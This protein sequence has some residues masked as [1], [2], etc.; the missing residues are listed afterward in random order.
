M[1]MSTRTLISLLLVLLSAVLSAQNELEDVRVETYYI[2][3]ANDATDEDGGTLLAGSRSYRIYVDLGPGCSLLA[4]FGDTNHVFSVSTNALFFNNADRGKTLGHEIAD[5]RLDE[6]TVALDSWL[7]L[8]GASTLRY[9]VEKSADTDGSLVGGANNDGGSAS[10]AGGLLV[11][12]DPDAGIPLTTQDGLAPLNGGTLPPPGTYLLGDDPASVLDVGT[13]GSEFTSGDF[14]LGCSS[15]GVAGPGASN[16]VLVAQLTTTGDLRFELNLIV[17]SADGTLIR[18]VANDSI[19]LP[20][21]Q[22]F[23]RLNYPPTCGCIDPNFLEFDP[24]AGCEEPGSCLTEIV[25]GCADVLA[26]NYDPAVNFNVPALCCYGPDD[27]NGLDIDLV[28]ID[29]G[30]SEEVV[31]SRVRIFPNPARDRIHLLSDT[32]FREGA[33]FR[34]MDAAGRCVRTWS[35]ASVQNGTCDIDISGLQGGTYVLGIA[36]STIRSTERFVVLP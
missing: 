23:A 19:L 17:S 16:S 18:Y 13:V 11:N 1:S 31:T 4:L 6:N 28:C 3:D 36:G 15:P 34:I 24:N 10:V 5:N 22:L 7:S 29:N 20:G 8:G 2:S 32:P 35:D 12:A 33:V 21:E 30:V 25:L 26:C 9:G 14:T 27:C